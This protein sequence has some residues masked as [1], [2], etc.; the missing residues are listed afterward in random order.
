MFSAQPPIGAKTTRRLD[1]DYASY[2][3]KFSLGDGPD[4]WVSDYMI[5]KESGKMLGTLV[6][7]AVAKMTSLETFIW[8]MPTGVL[9]D[10]FMALASVQDQ[11]PD[12][13]SR[14]ERVWVRWHDNSEGS[15]ASPRTNLGAAT[16]A[17]GGGSFGNTITPV[18]VLV[19]SSANPPRPRP[20]LSYAESTVE[21]PTFSILPPLKSLSVLDIDEVAYVDEMA[22]VIERSKDRLEELRVGIAAKASMKDFAQSWD[23][24]DLHQIDH[25]A[26]WP[27]ESGIGERRLGGVLG[28]L[29]GRIY[30]IRENSAAKKKV[31]C[32]EM[33]DSDVAASIPSQQDSAEQSKQTNL[34]TP[35]GSVQQQKASQQTHFSG[36]AVKD[37]P[38]CGE[39]PPTADTPQDN[40]LS[41]KARPKQ[42]STGYE[43]QDAKRRLDDRLRLKILELE[44]VPLSVHVCKQALDWSLLST[45]TLLD[46]AHS[47]ALWKMLRKQF[48]PTA[49]HHSRR[50]AGSQLQYHLVM[51]SI[52]TD[53]ASPALISF[54]KETL[55]PNTLEVLFLQDRRRAL[56]AVSI[57]QI[58]KGPIRRHR[59]SLR[60][61]LLDKPDYKATPN[62]II[63]DSDGWLK[64]VLPTK[65]VLFMMSGAMSGLREL[66]VCLH[67]QDWVSLETEATIS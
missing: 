28:V 54:L 5:T 30:D 35:S 55:A 46:C 43:K 52:H 23:G 31:K 44:R 26:R 38:S 48:Q 58:F 14:L 16:N 59:S 37:G 17:Q 21:F 40:G 49:A 64:W 53:S 61:L 39:S 22:A 63:P 25:N 3:K 47:E 60:K 41:V 24:P 20:A 13:R 65:V 9:A 29:V 45:L 32:T 33:A 2:I 57:E 36:N 15:P 56:P 8:D 18:G 1:N 27:G 11:D 12:N 4:D 6:A 10:I 50:S 66:S 67:Y 7:L 42:Q 51:K 19:P 62:G 34:G